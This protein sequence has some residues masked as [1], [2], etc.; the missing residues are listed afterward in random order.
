M[1]L[2]TC[3][4]QL[5][6]TII[7]MKPEFKARIVHGYTKD[8]MWCKT[9]ATLRANDEL[10]D[11]TAKLPFVLLDSLIYY[12]DPAYGERLCLPGDK[13]LLRDVFSMVHDHL[14]HAG[15]ARTHQRLTENVYIHRLPSLLKDYLA[16][17][18]ECRRNMTPR[19]CP[20]GSLQPIITPP[21]LFYMM[22]IDFIL[23]LPTSYPDGYDCV[24]SV[25]DKYTKKVT[26]V[27]G[28]FAAGAEEWADRLLRHLMLVE[29]GIPKVILSD[30][31]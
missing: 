13:S 26:F 22:T 11:N 28:F 18:A 19:H 15:Y 5:N 16:H 6:A 25:T 1:L 3:V 8:K 4:W 12:Q 27:P 29:W 14:G 7:K 10:E 17:C 20:Y 9:L 31:D 2:V 24:L 23:A 30:R 21:Q